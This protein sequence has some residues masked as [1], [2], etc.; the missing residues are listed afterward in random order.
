MIQFK[1]NDFLCLKLENSRTN[2]YVKNELF[3]QCKYLLLTISKGEFES[4]TLINS[5]DEAVELLDN[6]LEIQDNLTALLTPEAQFWGHCS[7]LQAWY[8]SNYDTR[9]LHSNLAFPLLKKLTEAGD[10]KAKKVFKDEIAKRFERGN[11]NSV[12]YLLE[13]E[14]LTY[15]N[16][17]EIECLLDQTAFNLTAD[18]VNELQLVWSEILDNRYWK[19]ADIIEILLFFVL[20]YDIKYI[21]QIIEAL[22]ERIKEDFVKKI[23][24]HLNYKE[25]R[26]Y[27]F[28]YGW[29]FSFFEKFLDYIHDNYPKIYNYLNLIDSG[30][31]NGALSLDDKFAIGTILSKSS[32]SSL[33][34]Y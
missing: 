5:I 34:L 3:I 22:P 10:T 20:K 12:I 2:I 19:I 4:T 23:I 30:Y 8:E 18:I 31:L 21:F 16:K 28:P 7:N 13:N 25:F 6:S 1:I 17:E 11:L 26:F 24:L 27:K 15:L 9:L 29:F 14:Y 32:N 33:S